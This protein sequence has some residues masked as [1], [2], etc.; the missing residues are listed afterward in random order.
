MLAT[1]RGRAPLVVL[2]CCGLVMFSATVFYHNRP[3]CACNSILLYARCHDQSW[4]RVRATEGS[5]V[6]HL[7]PADNVSRQY[8]LKSWPRPTPTTTLRRTTF[9]SWLLVRCCHRARYDKV[10]VKACHAY[11][12]NVLGWAIF[13]ACRCNGVFVVDEGLMKAMVDDAGRRV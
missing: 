2:R 12:I 5:Y 7:V 13:D 10:T 11:R 6:L 1:N 8:M 4:L 3:G 9:L